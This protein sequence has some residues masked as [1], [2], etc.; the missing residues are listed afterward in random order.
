MAIRGD[1]AAGAAHG[2]LTCIHLSRDF[3]S[4]PS[5]SDIK[6]VAIAAQVNA[7]IGNAH[8]STNLY[9]IS[10][11]TLRKGLVAAPAAVDAT[12][13]AGAATVAASGKVVTI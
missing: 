12:D 11:D 5:G 3:K 4:A 9:D 6:S 7:M 10:V 1:T 2:S 8:D 13:V